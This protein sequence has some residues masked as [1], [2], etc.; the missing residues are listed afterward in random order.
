[1][2]PF[3]VLWGH[4]EQLEEDVSESQNCN[5]DTEQAAKYL[6]LSPLTLRAWVAQRKIPH[7][8]VGRLVR[9]RRRD[10]DRWLDERFVESVA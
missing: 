3:D 2:E 7:V 9:F 1:M 10:L 8:R 5:M 4:T 6:R